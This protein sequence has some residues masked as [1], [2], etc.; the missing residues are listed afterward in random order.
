VDKAGR[1]A[2]GQAA[3]EA[4]DVLAAPPELAVL[5]AP[6][7]DPLLEDPDGPDEPELLAASLEPA[8]VLSALAAGFSLLLSPALLLP[9]LRS[10]RL[11]VR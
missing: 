11:S 6:L 1:P 2:L 10:D 5:L 3:L 4:F 9:P 8:E 7:D